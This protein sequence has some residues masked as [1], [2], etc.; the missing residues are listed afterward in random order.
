MTSPAMSPSNSCHG[1]S[2][3]TKG[4]FLVSRPLLVIGKAF[5]YPYFRVFLL[6][7]RSV[8]AYLGCLGNVTK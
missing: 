1:A 8:V 6:E 2:S 3:E 4:T 5:F 7:K